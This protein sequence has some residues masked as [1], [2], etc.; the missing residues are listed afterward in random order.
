MFNLCYVHTA[1]PIC[2]C[3]CIYCRLSDPI[4]VPLLILPDLHGYYGNLNKTNCN[5]L[6][7]T[8]SQI[9]ANQVWLTLHVVFVHTVRKDSGLCAFWQSN[10]ADIREVLWLPHIQRSCA[11]QREEAFSWQPVH[12]SYTCSVLSEQYRINSQQNQLKIKSGCR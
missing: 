6:W 1:T 10:S 7:W 5:G 8:G 9:C 2:L 4:C 11:F 3:D 12:T